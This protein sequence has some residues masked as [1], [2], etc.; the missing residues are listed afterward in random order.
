MCP[1]EAATV[2]ADRESDPPAATKIWENEHMPWK[3]PQYRSEPS[4]DR[5][6]YPPGVSVITQRSG[7]RA[8]WYSPEWSDGTLATE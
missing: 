7:P 5:D 6:E 3:D 4:C 2:S 1:Q 8:S